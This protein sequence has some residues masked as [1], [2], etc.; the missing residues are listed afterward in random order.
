LFY[1]PVFAYVKA[2]NKQLEKG[3]LNSSK[4]SV[5]SIDVPPLRLS[6]RKIFQICAESHFPS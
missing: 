4:Y 3:G 2:G 5:A 1:S 6:R